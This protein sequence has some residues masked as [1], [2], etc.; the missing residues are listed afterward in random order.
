MEFV[1]ATMNS[2]TGEMTGNVVISKGGYEAY[3]G[4]KILKAKGEEI[5]QNAIKKGKPEWNIKNF[6]IE[7]KEDVSESLKY[8][9]DFSFPDNVSAAV[10]YLNPMFSGRIESNP[11]TQ[12]ERL[13]PVDLAM[14]AD[15][16]YVANITIPEE[17]VVEEFPKSVNIALAEDMGKFTYAMEVA[18]NVIKVSS[19]ITLNEYHFAPEQYEMLKNFYDRI[20][21]KQA[22]QVILKK[23]K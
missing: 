6:K 14:G 12:Q 5:L 20:I 9:Y 13:Y 15:Q 22:E 17:Y 4:R 2:S 16:T 23:N 10:I 3:E 1:N 18:G 19:R 11:F 21:Q 7:N 8:T